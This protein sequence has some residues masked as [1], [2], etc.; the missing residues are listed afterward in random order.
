M[1]R[2]VAGSQLYVDA[3]LALKVVLL[4]LHT[5]LPAEELIEIEGL[6]LTVILMVLE[7]FPLALVAVRV[8]EYVPAV[9]KTT[10]GF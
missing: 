3:P 10:E 4:P 1:F 2:Y 9:E 6:V 7:L 8:T 5:E